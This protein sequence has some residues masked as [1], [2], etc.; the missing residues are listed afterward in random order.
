LSLK[1]TILITTCF[2]FIEKNGFAAPE[3]KVSTIIAELDETYDEESAANEK[4]TENFLAEDAGEIR[5]KYQRGVILT[6]GAA[7]PWQWV[8]LAYSRESNQISFG[9]GKDTT[10]RI[11]KD[12]G[13]G[14]N[15][16]HVAASVER[17]WFAV[18]EF[19]LALSYGVSYGTWKG[20]TRLNRNQSSAYSASGLIALVS[21]GLHVQRADRWFWGLSLIGTSR[22]IILSESGQ[23]LSGKVRD[24][25]EEQRNWGILNLSIGYFFE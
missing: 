18:T 3:N 16:S 1:L 22:A 19:P 20:T 7:K 2:L 6:L 17:R 24:I 15:L 12:I 23:K 11:V 4:D 25:L 9:G 8:N 13:I 5:S 21:L 10:E 14:M